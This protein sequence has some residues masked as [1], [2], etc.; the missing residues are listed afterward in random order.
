M[1]MNKAIVFISDKGYVMQT[2]VAITSL[3]ENKLP[4][5][6]YDIYIIGADLDEKDQS[7]FRQIENDG[8]KISVI[9]STAKKYEG[10]HT[11]TDGIYMVATHAALLKFDIP[12]LLKNYDKALYLDG[13]III[14]QDLG[15]LFDVDLENSY[16]AVVRDIPQVLFDKQ[17]IDTGNGVDYFNSG[18][19]LLNLKKM[20]DEQVK[21]RLVETKKNLSNQTLMDQNAFN[22]V[23][24]KNVLQLP[25]SY[26]VLYANLSRSWK[27]HNILEKLNKIYKTNYR[28][29]EDIYFHANI[30][31]YSSE[32]KP[33]KY[34]DAPLAEDWLY[35]YLK[36]PYANRPLYRKSILDKEIDQIPEVKKTEDKIAIVYA[37]NV[38]YVPYT[39][40]SIQSII[41][42]ASK[43]NEYD[44]YVFHSGI[45]EYRE[46]MLEG[47]STKNITIKCINIQ[48]L[49]N[50]MQDLYIRAHY[51]KEMYYR[52]YIPEILPQY[53]KVLYIDCDTVAIKDVKEL[54]N[55]DLGNKVIGG[56]VNICDPF[57][58]L[59]LRKDFSIL[60]EKYINSGILLINTRE[61]ILNKIKKECFRLVNI[62]E[63]GTLIC[64]DQDVIN[65]ACKDRI[66][67]LDDKWNVQWHHQWDREDQK[68]IYFV[69]KFERAKENI[70]ILHFTSG[71]K[72][73]NNPERPLAH[74]FWKYA[75]LSPV[76][77]AIIYKNVLDKVPTQVVHVEK[78]VNIEN[79]RDY[80]KEFEDMSTSVSFRVGRLIT[81]FPRKIRGA[82]WCCKDH[83]LLYTVHRFFEK[84]LN[85]IK[86]KKD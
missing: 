77:E 43:T 62:L 53:K 82:I 21:T 38:N 29:L 17:L 68:L 24:G 31:H 26:N 32:D 40:V 83:G 60:S 49:S 15:E 64:P 75:R 85:F 5:S 18:V 37:T 33:W 51:S 39:S 34:F 47:M 50:Q 57:T 28:S 72:P 25:I 11:R 41:E 56:I 16:A 6:K 42:T 79:F 58:R 12:E 44:I 46:Q 84:I 45:E 4:N 71:I 70:G 36:S 48:E 74:Y 19:M 86:G 61:F 63:N 81:F 27:N 59:R 2:A 20:R 9:Q 66:M 55:T 14:H 3:A 52:W 78:K 80:K 65:I 73:W 1:K 35:Y 23:F 67:L 54:F 8:I 7:I 22:I 10:L 30:V 69:N 13:D 76:Y